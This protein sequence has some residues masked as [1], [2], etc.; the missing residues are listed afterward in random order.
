MNEFKQVSTTRIWK[1]K[2][3]WNID[4]KNEISDV[5]KLHY[6]LFNLDQIIAFTSLSIKENEFFF[7]IYEKTPTSIHT[8][9]IIQYLIKKATVLKISKLNCYYEEKNDIV[10]KQLGFEKFYSSKYA[11]QLF[12]LKLKK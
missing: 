9:E 5:K 4:D 10:Y 6:G 1:L 11:K 3:E 8:A 7:V 2:K 12:S